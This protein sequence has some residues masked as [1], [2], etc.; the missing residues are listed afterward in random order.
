MTLSDKINKLI[1]AIGGPSQPGLASIKGLL[2]QFSALAKAMEEDQATAEADMKRL[3][4]QT[5]D[6]HKANE[7]LTNDLAL[8]KNQQADPQKAA[9]ENLSDEAL[10][11]LLRL[12]LLD[13]ALNAREVAHIRILAEPLAQQHLEELRIA[14]LINYTASD[15]GDPVW[16]L[17]RKGRAYLEARNLLIRPD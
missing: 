5:A 4:G 3:E 17:T 11:I 7:L 12:S 6:L 10:D 8:L 9:A 15:S 14:D 16:S 2:V 1:S 13:W